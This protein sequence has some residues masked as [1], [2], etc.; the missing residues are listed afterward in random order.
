MCL[1]KNIFLRLAVA[2][3]FIF[4]LTCCKLRFRGV[5]PTRGLVLKETWRGNAVIYF[6]FWRFE[7]SG[8]VE[9]HPLA[10]I[11]MVGNPAELSSPHTAIT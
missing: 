11:G 10:L 6:F 1:N 8:L 3:L 5:F 7:F 9:E 4:K 2:F